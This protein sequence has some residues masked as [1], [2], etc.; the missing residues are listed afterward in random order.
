[1]LREALE[2]TL[3]WTAVFEWHSSFRSDQVSFEDD[4]CPGPLGINKV[5]NSLKHF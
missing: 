5:T 3:S 1:M 2:H 4:E